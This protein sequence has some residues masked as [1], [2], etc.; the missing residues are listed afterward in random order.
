VGRCAT[1]LDLQRVDSSLRLLWGRCYRRDCHNHSRHVR[2]CVTSL[3]P[4]VAA[5][6]TAPCAMAANWLAV[7]RGRDDAVRLLLVR[8]D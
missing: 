1:D 3:S 4:P 7:D 6:A 8:E 5:A 2:A